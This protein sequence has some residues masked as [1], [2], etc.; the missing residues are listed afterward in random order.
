MK[1]AIVIGASGFVGSLL[2]ED[3][4]NNPDYDQVTVVVRKDLKIDHPKLKML[5]GDF[6]TLSNLKEKISGDEIFLTIG[7]TK[8]NTPDVKE[9]Y[10]ADHDYPVLAA[11]IAKENGTKSVFVV[12][13]VG[14]N[15][16]SGMFY[17]RTK[18]EIERNLIA[19]NFD[20]THIFR[21]SM[22]MGNRKESRS[23]EK[24][25]IN[26]FGAINPL[27]IGGMKIY[28]GID[29]KYIAKSMMNAAKVQTEKIKIYH[30]KEMHDL[31]R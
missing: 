29:G 30:C 15:A 16:S 11:K 6:H 8:K 25:L 4:L 12:T 20:H 2:M 26:I 10:Q 17:I 27:F 13:A 18:G 9:Y 28:R 1:K 19:L 14:A 22:I 23:F 31:S 5:I 21:P 7:T 3:L 24:V